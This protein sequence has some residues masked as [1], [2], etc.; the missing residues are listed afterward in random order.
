MAGLNKKSATFNPFTTPKT[1]NGG[2]TPLMT[3][4]MGRKGQTSKPSNKTAT[5]R[6]N[7]YAARAAATTRGP[8]DPVGM[9]RSIRAANRRR[10]FE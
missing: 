7:A 9:V 3:T 1:V 6:Q 4:G 10:E 2:R 8:I 5:N